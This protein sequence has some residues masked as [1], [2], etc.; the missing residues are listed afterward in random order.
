MTR[1]DGI[2]L[3]AGVSGGLALAVMLAA[4]AI[5][6]TRFA[7][8]FAGGLVGLGLARLALHLAGADHV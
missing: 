2:L 3:L 1:T 4:K 7:Q 5:T 6:P 8:A